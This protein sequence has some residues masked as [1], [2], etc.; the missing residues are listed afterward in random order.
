MQGAYKMFIALHFIVIL[1]PILNQS[2]ERNLKIKYIK[3]S[4]TKCFVCSNDFINCLLFLDSA[5]AMSSFKTKIKKD[6][7]EDDARKEK[8]RQKFRKFKRNQK[9][10]AKSAESSSS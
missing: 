9:L 4:I 8:K 1:Y 6:K 10:K 5:A 2:D 3:E 7:S